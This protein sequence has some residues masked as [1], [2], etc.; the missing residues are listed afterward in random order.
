MD[1]KAEIAEKRRQHLA[2]VRP[3]TG[4]KP[5][6]QTKI[7]RTLKEAILLAAEVTGSDKKGKDGL[8]GFLVAQAQRAD[9]RGFM[10][11]LGKVLP[12]TVAFDKNRPLQVE[13]RIELVRP[14]GESAAPPID[15]TPRRTVTIE[16]VVEPAPAPRAPV[17]VRP[18]RRG[19]S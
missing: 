15:V 17:T 14:T 2:R 13:T 5:G 3:T 1:R 18:P 7:T 10:M 11:L 4:R 12:M 19:R 8:V 6:Q 16:N 9:N